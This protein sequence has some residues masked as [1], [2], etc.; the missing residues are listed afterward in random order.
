MKIQ[1]KK[2]KNYTQRPNK[3]RILPLNRW[4]LENLLGSMCRTLCMYAQW[5]VSFCITYGKH[6][7]SWVKSKPGSGPGFLTEASTANISEIQMYENFYRLTASPFQ[8]T[9][10]SDF[11]YVTSKHENA[12]AYLRYGLIQ[13]AGFTLLTGEIGTGK[14]TVVLY[15]LRR[16]CRKMKTALVSNT[17]ISA[18]QLLILILKKFGLSLIVL[19][20]NRSISSGKKGSVFSISTQT[21][22]L[23]PLRTFPDSS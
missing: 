7:P 11:F 3:L 22:I 2:S 21:R 9:P 5:F 17:N 20:K 1:S 12:L 23:E 4:Y 10:D 16:Y 19:L 18:D 14:T 13:K 6:H 15:F 8:I